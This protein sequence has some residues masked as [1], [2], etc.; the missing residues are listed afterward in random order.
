MSEHPVDREPSGHE[1]GTI[2]LLDCGDGIMRVDF[3][4]IW[5]VAGLFGGLGLV[6]AALLLKKHTSDTGLRHAIAVTLEEAM[7]CCR[8]ACAQRAVDGTGV[9]DCAVSAVVW[10]V[11]RC[12]I[13]GC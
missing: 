6:I 3:L 8:A 11:P 2:C 7:S 12:W 4:R 9:C 5:L 1:V 10:V 13:R